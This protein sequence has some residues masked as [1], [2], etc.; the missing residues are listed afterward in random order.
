VSSKRT[1]RFI[2]RFRVFMPIRGVA[3]HC[4][5]IARGRTFLTLRFFLRLRSRQ[6]RYLSRPAAGLK[7]IFQ[8]ERSRNLSRPV[9]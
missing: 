6:T 8:P 2:F 3:V 4:F 7:C 9:F 5:G 1:V